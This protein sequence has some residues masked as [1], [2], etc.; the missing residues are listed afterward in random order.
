MARTAV[1]A[2]ILPALST[3]TPAAGNINLE[4]R[5]AAQTVPPGS[6]ISVG[7]Y[8]VS[9]SSQP[10]TLSAAQVIITWDVNFVQLQGL[11]TAGAATLLVSSFG[12]EPYGLNASL[13]DGDAMWLGLAPLGSGNAVPATPQGTLLTTFLFTAL[14]PTSQTQVNIAASAGNPPGQTIVYSGETPNTIV[15]GT[16]AGATLVIQTPCGPDVNHDQHVDVLDLLAVISAW[17]PCPGPPQ[18][19]DPDIN[20]DQFIDVLDLLAVINAWGPCP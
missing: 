4:L 12:A 18:G 11:T 19:C 7:L 15:T 2:I 20:L 13:L 10:Q 3:V 8:A 9:D 6:T 17:G 5:P 1:A 16:L 14:N